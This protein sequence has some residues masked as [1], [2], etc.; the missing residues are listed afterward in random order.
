LSLNS[1]LVTKQAWDLKKIQI[2]NHPN[3]ANTHAKTSI[4]YLF[5][6]G[7]KIVTDKKLLIEA[8]EI[9]K[10]LLPSGNPVTLAAGAL[11][12]VCKKETRVTKEQIAEAFKIS[13]RTVYTN[14]ARI[15]KIL[16]C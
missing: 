7:G 14:E 15:R 9:L 3:S 4:D 5:N 8:E 16:N 12:Y 10:N 11:Y 1:R 6:F 2:N 13:H